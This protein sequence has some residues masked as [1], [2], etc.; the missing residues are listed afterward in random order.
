MAKPEPG[1]HQGME[2]LNDALQGMLAGSEHFS[3]DSF[4]ALVLERMMADGVLELKPGC[5]KEQTAAMFA[6]A[7]RNLNL[8][9]PANS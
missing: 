8:K 4:A 7:F 1:L 5:T 9:L 6:S 3:A 2:F